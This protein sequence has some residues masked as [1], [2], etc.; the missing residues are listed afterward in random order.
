MG[1]AAV[2]LRAAPE[3][4]PQPLGSPQRLGPAARSLPP[5]SNHRH[6][7]LPAPPQHLAVRAERGRRHPVSGG[8]CQRGWGGRAGFGGLAR[9]RRRLRPEGTGALP[10]RREGRGR[11]QPAPFL[12]FTFLPALLS[13]PFLHFPLPPRHAALFPLLSMR[14][15]FQT[16]SSQ[17]KAGPGEKCNSGPRLF[18]FV[19]RET[20]A[21]FF[22]TNRRLGNAAG[23]FNGL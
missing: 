22:T 18:E 16:T 8:G 14:V 13:S 20:E 5:S 10:E 4:S 3:G 2:A 12:A 7:P 1:R 17:N 23:V 6:V 19:Q 9:P 21:G 11:V 15:G